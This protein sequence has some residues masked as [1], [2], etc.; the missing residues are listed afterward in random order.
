MDIEMVVRSTQKVGS[1]TKPKLRSGPFSDLIISRL[2]GDYAEAAS[3]DLLYHAVLAATTGTIA[4]GNING[5]AAAAST[6][7]ALWNPPGTGV[8]LEIVKFF[9]AAISGTPP[10]GPVFHSFMLGTPSNTV[11][12]APGLSALTGSN[13]SSAR[14]LASAAGTAL[15]GMANGPTVL[16]PSSINLFAAALAAGANIE[17]TLELVEGDIVVQPGWMWVPTW[18]AAGTLFLNAYGVSWLEVA[19]V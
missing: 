2:R 14:F 12:G 11:G 9:V 18:A 8:N 5:A 19:I 10:G 16:R 4:A 15:T 13:S 3:S 7:F 17:N 6:Q 1:N